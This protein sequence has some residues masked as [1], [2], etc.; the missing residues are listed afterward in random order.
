MDQGISALIIVCG[1]V[2]G[3]VGIAV[4]SRRRKHRLRAETDDLG[5]RLGARWFT[6]E[7][8][9]PFGRV[10][11]PLTDTPY[12]GTGKAFDYAFAAEYRGR[13][14]VLLEYSTQTVTSG[15]TSRTSHHSIQVLGP[16]TTPIKIIS[17]ALALP[18]VLFGGLTEAP[19]GHARFDEQFRVLAKDPATVAGAVP[20]SVI[21]WLLAH[22]QG[23]AAMI[24][25][26]GDGF[27]IAM[28][29]PLPG[30]DATR[31]L[32]ELV[33][34]ADVYESGAVRLSQRLELTTQQP[35]GNK[36]L[37]IGAGCLIGATVIFWIT[38]FT[39][40]NPSSGL[41]VIAVLVGL[42]A[43][44]VLLNRLLA[45]RRSPGATSPSGPPGP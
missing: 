8:G 6:A 18:T 27:E 45:R 14:V 7:L 9:L 31:T 28:P 34:L 43:V 13:R 15:S 37:S 2:I 32:N 26:A 41:V 17:R 39:I 25:F 5:R 16:R 38:A 30:W 35:P 19:T 11:D 3:F 36:A 44:G 29:G 1:F 20:P 23:Q 10:A 42:V 24:T 21:D 40:S 4:A 12:T 33:D 22:P